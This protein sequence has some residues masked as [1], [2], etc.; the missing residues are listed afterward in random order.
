MDIKFCI[1]A[2]TGKE[3][4]YIEEAISSGQL[5]G[6]GA[7]T[8]KCS[9]W[10]FDYSEGSTSLLTPS[11][12][13]AL[14]MTAL[15]IDIQPG[16]EVIMPSFT[17]V[18]TAN[19]FVLRGAKIVFVDIKP[20]DLNID[21]TK[22]EAAIT[23]K[24]KAIVPVHYA[25]IPCEMDTIMSIAKE[26]NL[27]VIE[28]AAQGLK[29]TYKGRPLGTIGHFGA[30]SFH[31]TKNFTSGGEGGLLFVNDASYKHRAEV[32]REKGTDRS[33]FF[34][35]DIDKYTW[36]DIGS[37]MLPSELQMA[38]LWAQLEGIEDLH[39]AR[40]NIWENYYNAFS[41]N[42]FVTSQPPKGNSSLHN[43]HIFYVMGEKSNRHYLPMFREKGIQ[44][45]SH[46]EP[47]HSSDMGQRHGRVS[48]S[49]EHTDYLSSHVIRLPI[50]ASLA[51]KD[52]DFII[53]VTKK[54][55]T[56]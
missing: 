36:R 50:Y 55:L 19:A 52:V 30:L 26:H 24:T 53:D 22:I 56:S 11:C 21:E 14:E 32:I 42:A 17:F 46:Y 23:N 25:G 10:F 1:A 13:H 16:D 18:S 34:R 3:Q 47:L 45:T 28:D 27:I 29:S 35:G 20:E 38:Y 5:A 39:D 44:A 49:M 7:F 9:K 41:S 33:A 31:T 37:S 15:L 4:A 48:G 51:Q 40:M 12:T 2:K 8:K 6:D 54:A 43:G